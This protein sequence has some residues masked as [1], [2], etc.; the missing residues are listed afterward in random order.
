[1][2]KED[3]LSW[4]QALS[5]FRPS[6]LIDRLGLDRLSLVLIIIALLVAMPIFTLFV[7][8]LSGDFSSLSHLVKNVI[9]HA[10]KTTFLLL[11]GIAFLTAIIGSLSA[12]LVSFF[13]FP[14]RKTLSIALMLPLAVP[15]YINAYAFVEF[16]GFTGPI[17]S[18]VRNIF[19]FTSSR[20]YWFFE[21]RSLGGAIIVLSLVLYPYVYLSMRAIFYLQ[22]RK[23]IEAASLLGAGHGR[24]FTN[25][26]LP[27]ARPALALGVILVLMEAINDIGAMEYLGV[28]TLTFSIYSVWLNQGDFA[29]AAQIALILLVIILALV[30]FERLARNK[31]VFSEKEASIKINGFQRV[32]L[33]GF[34]K[35]VALFASLTPV[36][37]GFGIPFFILGFFALR[38]LKTGFDASLINA[39]FTSISL[40]TIAAIITVMVALFLSYAIRIKNTKTI[41]TLVRLATLGYALPGTIIALGIFL[42]LARFDNFVDFYMR[43]WFG[44]STGLLLT[45]SSITLIF[46]YVV[47][48]MVIAEGTISAGFEKIPNTLDQASLCYGKSR[49][50]T[51]FKILLPLM[52]PAIATAALLVFIDVLK[53]LSATLMLRPFGLETLS[54][55]I[56]DLASRGRIEQAGLASLII[57]LAG[58]IPIIILMKT[59]QK[60]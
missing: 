57:M 50:D 59:L 60:S 10:S 56:H 38:S 9:P 41:R 49:F 5:G 29:G 7:I 21:I 45:G 55:Y 43:D 34:A 40:A 36:I 12:W 17:Q 18:L 26:L 28:K 39:L 52:R 8:A 42:P 32:K 1:M 27:L 48:F 25:I 23:V 44:F 11:F 51:F 4:W 35:W 54:I 16:F 15:T 33:N 3:K 20:D 46:A 24:I 47:R 13:E 19:G 30:I 53:E 22:G 14:F 6:L 31:Q 37:L 2:R 58:L